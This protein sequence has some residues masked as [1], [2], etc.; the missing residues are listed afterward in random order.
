MNWPEL[1]QDLRAADM[2]QMQIA[3]FAGCNQSSIS[4]LARG[5]TKQPSFEI[6]EKLQTLHKRAKRRLKSKAR[7]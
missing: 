6:G 4:D 1:L 7:A 2:T 5:L 3:A